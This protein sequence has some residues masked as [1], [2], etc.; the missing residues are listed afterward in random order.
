MKKKEAD[1]LKQQKLK[2]DALAKKREEQEKRSADAL[3]KAKD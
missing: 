2:E 1:K 3:K